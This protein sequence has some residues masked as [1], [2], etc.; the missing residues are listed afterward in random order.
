MCFKNLDIMFI[1]EILF[2]GLVSQNPV[3]C[4]TSSIILPSLNF[5]K[6]NSPMEALPSSKAF[7]GP[8]RRE[9]AIGCK[10]YDVGQLIFELLHSFVVRG[11][12]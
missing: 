9:S 1:L 6:I 11:L 2:Y 5:G 4:T 7:V 10:E 8:Q 12:G 3:T